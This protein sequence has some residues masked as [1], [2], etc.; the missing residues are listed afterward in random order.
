MVARSSS[1]WRL[2]A[3]HGDHGVGVSSYGA[4]GHHGVEFPSPRLARATVA[5]TSAS[6]SGEHE[7][8]GLSVFVYYPGK[9]AQFLSRFELVHFEFD[10]GN[11]QSASLRLSSI[12]SVLAAS[13]KNV[14][15]VLGLTCNRAR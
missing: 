15:W 10:L 8:T 13:L 9:G 6:L 1:L 4:P 2:K 3:A 5:R 7:Q 14:N 12:R 11:A